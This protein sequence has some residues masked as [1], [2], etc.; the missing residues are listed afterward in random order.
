MAI[1]ILQSLDNTGDVLVERVPR[2]GS[3]DIAYG[4]QVVVRESQEAIFFRDGQALDRFAPGRHTVTSANI[5]LLRGL[6]KLPFGGQTPFK[7]EVYFIN[8]KVFTDLKWGTPQPVAFRDAEFGIVR[9]R[10]HGIYSLR[11]TDSGLFVNKYVGTGN[12]KMVGEL[13][14]FL[15]G[16]IVSQTFDFL[17]GQVK[18]LLDL[19]PLYDEFA[20]ALKAQLTEEVATY[21]IELVD[22]TVGA[23]TAPPEVE[24]AM[25]ERAKMGAIGDMDRYTRYKT[26]EAIGDAAKQPGGGGMA[27]MGAGLGAGM[28]IGGQMADAMKDKGGSKAAPEKVVVCGKCGHENPAG[29]KFCGKCGAAL[30]PV[31]PKCGAE[32]VPGDKFC[33]KCG[34]ALK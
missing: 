4:G 10:A 6:L 31:C 25:D 12:M 17:G 22:F 32:L 28:A 26:A 30:K 2:D 24:K 15:R 11:I 9:L 33:G 18:S 8:K 20:I 19:P 3:G 23:I 14:D 29:E 7:V 1:E 34:K 27:G 21:G 5:P 16:I 13:E